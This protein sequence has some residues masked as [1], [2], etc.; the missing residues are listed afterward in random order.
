ML[1]I[2]TAAELMTPELEARWA[3]RRDERQSAVL[4]HILRTFLARGGPIPLDALVAAFPDW[5]PGALRELLT[6]LDEQDLIQLGGGGIEVAY[7]FS[8]GPTPFVVRLSDGR[9]RY[10]CCAVDALGIAAMLEERVHVRSRCHH[11]GDPLELTVDP[12][13]PASDADGIMVWV[14]T[15]GPGDCRRS[16]G[17]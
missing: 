15:R 6:A 13:G 5:P 16:T 10:A 1:E 4:Q 14:G 17:L 8:S 3:A 11:C 2:K 12:E 9:E 7:P